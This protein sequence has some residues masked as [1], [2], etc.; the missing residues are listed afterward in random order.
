ML[1]STRRPPRSSNRTGSNRRTSSRRKGLTTER[2]VEV[3]FEPDRNCCVAAGRW[4]G[5][6]TGTYVDTPGDLDIDHLVPLKNA[7][8]SD[9]WAWR[10]ARKEDYAKYLRDPDHLIAVTQT[11]NRSKGAKGPE[12]WGTPPRRSQNLRRSSPFT[13]R[14]R[15]RRQL[16]SQGCRGAWAREEDF[17]KPWRLALGMETVMR[18][19]V[20]GD[21]C[22]LTWSAECV[23][24]LDHSVENTVIA[25]H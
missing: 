17:R 23:N 8:D 5:A 19:F 16:G 20:R 14:A 13:S 10:S 22:K 25:N 6:L 7:H 1:M 9:G 24:G 4:Y 15:K 21:T 18:S 3:T 2:L 12:E 11:A